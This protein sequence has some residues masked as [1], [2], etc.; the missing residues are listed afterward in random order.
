MGSDLFPVGPND[1]DGFGSE[2]DVEAPV[3]V[4]GRHRVETVPDTDPEDVNSW[5]PFFGG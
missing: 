1:R 4:S 2:F 3:N 5:L